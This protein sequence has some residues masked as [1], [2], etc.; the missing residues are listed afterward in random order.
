MQINAASEHALSDHS[1]E[2]DYALHSAGGTILSRSTTYRHP[3][4]SFLAHVGAHVV[5]RL[6][7]RESQH[8]IQVPLNLDTPIQ[9]HL[10][11]YLFALTDQRADAG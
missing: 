4:S 5:D 9:R 1:S 10:M 11:E 3:Q 7:R 6:T 2:I 8:P